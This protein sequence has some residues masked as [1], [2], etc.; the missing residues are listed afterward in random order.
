MGIPPRSSQAGDGREETP[1][2]RFDR[3]WNEILQELRVTQTGTQI[4]SGFLL[5]VAFQQ[6]F[7]ELDNFQMTVY[8]TLVILAASAT[9][10]GLA[11]VSLHRTLFRHHEKRQTV[12]IGN[13][14]LDATLVLVALLT[15]GVVL[16]IFD[17]VAGLFAGVIAGTVIVV[18]L[19]FV[20]VVLPRS[21][22]HR[23]PGY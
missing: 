11:P 3:N 14:L 20:L 8:L 7:A 9:A 15:G 5:T 18:L 16:F 4:I 22:R 6:R 19:A 12:E 23:G 10:V 1:N 17:V 21:A 2:E 13:R